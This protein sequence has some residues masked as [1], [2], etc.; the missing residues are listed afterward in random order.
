MLPP[1]R[2]IFAL[3]MIFTPL[4]PPCAALLSCRHAACYAYAADY[5]RVSLFDAA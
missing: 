3:T 5:L 2:F 4:M 1:R